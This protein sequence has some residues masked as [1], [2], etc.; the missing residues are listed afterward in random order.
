MLSKEEILAYAQQGTPMPGWIVLRPHMAYLARQAII[1][2]ILAIIV[3][4][5]GIAFLSQN[6]FVVTPG[7]GTGTVDPGSFQLWRTI[8]LIVLALFFC[9]MAGVALVNVS[10][11][12]T[13][14]QQLIVLMPEG[15]LVKKRRSEQLVAYTGVNSISPRVD[16]YGRVT[17]NI[18]AAQTN[19][20][21]KVQFDNRYGKSR[22]LA[23]QIVNA[24]RQALAARQA[25][26]ASPQV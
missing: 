10:D 4:G 11:L 13:V 12:S 6:Q 18:R 17:M 7:Y 24:H 25:R 22:G 19:A 2:G 1:Y 23:S 15:F 16:R 20:L 14:D 3:V 21:Y 8:D 5:L 9:V 26:A